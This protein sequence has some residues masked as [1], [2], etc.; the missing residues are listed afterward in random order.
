MIRPIVQFL[1]KRKA[2]EDARIP[3]KVQGNLIMRVAVVAI[4]DDLEQFAHVTSYVKELRNR[5]L[6]TV[7]LYPFF[8]NKK[9]F[10]AFQGGLKDFPFTRKDFNLMG[11]FK[12]D[13]LRHSVGVSYDVLID[14]TRGKA[15]PCDV[16]ISK[17]EARWKA[18][19]Y[20]ADR[21][22]L[23]DLMLDVKQNPDIRQLIH[24]LDHYLKNFNKSNAA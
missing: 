21:E 7:D 9:R 24:H 4:G 18:G 14:L 8:H 13:M 11:K 6:K 20:D 10:E 3:S 19:E 23:L 5:G 12:S 22:H 1:I 15:F 16:L 17:I 2:R